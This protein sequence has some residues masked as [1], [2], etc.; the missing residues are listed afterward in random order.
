MST[1]RMKGVRVTSLAEFRDNFDFT[2]AKDYL[3]QGRL[4]RWVRDLGENGLAD[5]LDELK[6]ADYSD[7]TLMDNFIGIFSLPVES[8]AP[9]SCAPAQPD[10]PGC[11]A[12][13]EYSQK[14]NDIRTKLENPDF[15][16]TISAPRGPQVIAGLLDLLHEYY[17]K[18]SAALRKAPGRAISS[19]KWE[20]YPTN[21]AEYSPF[22]RCIELLNNKLTGG[23]DF[24]WSDLPQR[25]T[26][27]TV[28][29]PEQREKTKAIAAYYVCF[30][31]FEYRLA[32][33]P[34][35]SASKSR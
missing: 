18:W 19:N 8:P 22:I 31:E 30:V 17:E 10:E 5:E 1:L 2:N 15:S 34:R 23:D 7:K 32:H 13:P 4:S 14:V 21:L 12:K 27:T 20:L 11:A 33:R 9:E 28:S 24:P 16:G 29:Y 6:V 3:R 26:W 35:R 25:I